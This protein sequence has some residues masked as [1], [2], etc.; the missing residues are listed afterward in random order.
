MPLESVGASW[1]GGLVL[2]VGVPERES[3]LHVFHARL[4]LRYCVLLRRVA[5]V[6]F[7][8]AIDYQLGFA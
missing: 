5:R 7:G 2:P 1:W 8:S 6:Q 3:F 4:Q